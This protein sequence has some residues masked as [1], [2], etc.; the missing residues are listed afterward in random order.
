VTNP[1]IQA[2]TAIVDVVPMPR[3][4]KRESHG[5]REVSQVLSAE[6]VKLPGEHIRDVDLRRE[7]RFWA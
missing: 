7:D 1:L 6:R 3:R 2:W 4:M 5:N